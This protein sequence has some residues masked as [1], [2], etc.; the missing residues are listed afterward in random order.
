MSDQLLHRLQAKHPYP[1]TVALAITERCNLACKHCYLPAE[2]HCTELSLSEIEDLLDELA[3]LG[4][5]FFL[6]TGGEPALR[7]D[8]EEIVA[9]AVD[10]RFSVVL[11]TSATLLHEPRLR[12]LVAAG[13]G[14]V[15]VSLYDDRP[16]EHD[17]FVGHPGAWH[18][19]LT[20]LDFLSAARV[21]VVA[22]IVALRNNAERIPRIIDLCSERGFPYSISMRMVPSTDGDRAPCAL[23]L[24]VDQIERLLEDRRLFAPSDLFDPCN[25]RSDGALCGAGIGLA[26]IGPDGR[27]FLCPIVPME[28]GNIRE[29]PFR[30][31]WQSSTER[32]RFIE[33]AWSDL[34]TCSK[35]EDAWAC[36]RCPGAALLESGNL[37]GVSPVDCEMAKA[38]ALV[39]RRISDE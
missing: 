25:H 10:R 26:H 1:L 3:A 36:N 12:A 31:L 4:T 22:N 16:A 34:P 14:E 11:K 32:R 30:E 23:R 18:R 27:V 15:H 7:R 20:A 33:T 2:P 24:D 19:T 29:R 28:V 38:R 35:C 9:A 6:I 17:A 21:N 13:L 5:L 8:L 39:C 37:V